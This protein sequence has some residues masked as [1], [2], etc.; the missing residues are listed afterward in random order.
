MLLSTVA[1]AEAPL[2]GCSELATRLESFLSTRQITV[3]NAEWS[4]KELQEFHSFLLEAMALD[5]ANVPSEKT[6]ID[7]LPDSLNSRLQQEF[8][9]LANRR[10]VV[11]AFGLEED[12]DNYITLVQGLLL[13]RER[14]MYTRARRVVK[15]GSLHD[16]Y[17]SLMTQ[18]KDKAPGQIEFKV[19][20][21][22]EA[23]DAL[24]EEMKTLSSQFKDHSARAPAASQ[25]AATQERLRLIQSLMLIFVPI[26]FLTGLCAGLLWKRKSQFV[27]DGG[28]EPRF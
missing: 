22:Q 2:N 4:W 20:W 8:I 21:N 26:V 10:Q 27:A 1:S 17:N 18:L 24:V 16:A 9:K 6:P 28:S 3:S 12:F 5:P 11:E 25:D 14:G 15:Q 23:S 19:S 13:Q 7:L